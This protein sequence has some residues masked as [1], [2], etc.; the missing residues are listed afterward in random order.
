M[1]GSRESL[2]AR[3]GDPDRDVRDVT[4]SRR[5]IREANHDP[6]DGNS[7]EQRPAPNHT[8]SELMQLKGEASGSSRG[9]ARRVP[10]RPAFDAPTSM[11]FFRSLYSLLVSEGADEHL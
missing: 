4:S 10:S 3:Q 8:Y 7:T 1:L 6:R 9:A 2:D 5:S 11:H